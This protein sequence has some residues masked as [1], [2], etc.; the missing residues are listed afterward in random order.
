[1][2]DVQDIQSDKTI[3]VAFL[4]AI[5]S[6][7][8]YITDFL[9]VHIQLLIEGQLKEQSDQA[10]RYQRGNAWCTLTLA[11]LRMPTSIS[12]LGM[13]NALWQ[14]A[15]IWMQPRWWCY[16]YRLDRTWHYLIMDANEHT[17]SDHHVSLSSSLLFGRRVA[18]ISSE[19]LL[20][21]PA[22]RLDTMAFG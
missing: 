16:M 18:G 4:E 1:M 12:V 8:R 22:K 3:Y 9:S 13:Q 14:G 21:M 19:M 17:M 20:H 11:F 2:N 7:L 6:R 10:A 5:R 15:C